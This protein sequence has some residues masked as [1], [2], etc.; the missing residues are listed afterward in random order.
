MMSS[1]VLKAL[2]TSAS[3]T[4]PT[5]RRRRTPNIKAVEEA[6]VRVVGALTLG[7]G[8]L[9]RIRPEV[10]KQR[11]DCFLFNWLDMMNYLLNRG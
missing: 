1:R 3:F 9:V 11:V 4:P 8:R 10:W 5:L 7:P 6:A 2:I